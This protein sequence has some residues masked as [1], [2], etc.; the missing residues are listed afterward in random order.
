MGAAHAPRQVVS[1]VLDAMAYREGDFDSA[2]G[3]SLTSAPARQI[4]R[5]GELDGRIVDTTDGNGQ[6]R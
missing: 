5:A 2:R 3:C 6:G 1:S 4:A